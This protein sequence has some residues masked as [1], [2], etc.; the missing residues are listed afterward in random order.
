MSDDF[1]I[2]MDVKPAFKEV[3]GYPRAIENHNLFAFSILQFVEREA[4]EPGAKEEFRDALAAYKK[5]LWSEE[6]DEISGAK[7]V[8]Y[9]IAGSKGIPAIS[10]PVFTQHVEAYTAARMDTIL[11]Q[12]KG[13]H[14]ALQKL[15]D[16]L[17]DKLK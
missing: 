4:T 14:G 6:E 10:I 5:A 1:S 15:G 8:L 17:S 7:A 12:K 2:F 9:F 3:E 13:L 11:Y 16:A